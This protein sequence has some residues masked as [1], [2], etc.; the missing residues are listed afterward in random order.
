MVS[1]F[2][3]A[4]QHASAT[5]FRIIR[6][7]SHA[8]HVQTLLHRGGLT[9]RC[10]TLAGEQREWRGE[11]CPAS[12]FTIAHRCERITNP[13]ADCATWLNPAVLWVMTRLHAMTPPTAITS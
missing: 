4:R 3:I 1:G 13:G 8:Y 2:R 9:L 7:R 10:S 11:Y 12:G 6:M 5:G